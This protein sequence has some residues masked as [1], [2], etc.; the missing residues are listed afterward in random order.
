MKRKHRSGKRVYWGRGNFGEQRFNESLPRAL[1]RVAIDVERLQGGKQGEPAGEGM[2][3]IS[4]NTDCMKL[5]EI[6]EGIGKGADAGRVCD[7][8]REVLEIRKKD[9]EDAQRVGRD[10]ELLETDAEG[11]GRWEGV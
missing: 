3:F 1:E 4:T 8:D 5:V 6:D 11:E 7:D 2:H 10:V 9:G